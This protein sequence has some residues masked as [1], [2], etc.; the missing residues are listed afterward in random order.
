MDLAIMLS[1]HFFNPANLNVIFTK[2]SVKMRLTGHGTITDIVIVFAIMI[3]VAAVATFIVRAL[4]Y[5][6]P[7]TDI[8]VPTKQL[9]SHQ[10]FLRHTL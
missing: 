8:I 6:E 5:G 7:A 9:I 10:P 1:V 2:I 3:G 4:I